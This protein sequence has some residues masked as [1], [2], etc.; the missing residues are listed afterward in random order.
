M[1]LGG[2]VMSCECSTSSTNNNSNANRSANCVADTVRFINRLQQAVVPS[3]IGCSR[4]NTPVLGETSKA[5]TRP[6][7][8]YLPNGSAFR[9]ATLTDSPNEP[10]P[11]FRVEDV[12]GNCAT[13]RALTTPCRNGK[14]LDNQ[15]EFYGCSSLQSDEFLP[16]R[17]C[18]IVNLNDFM[19]IQCLNDVF[20]NLEMCDCY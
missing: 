4:C 10:I 8:L 20:L 1:Y 16:T 6:F 12:N 9:V 14:G 18:V 7:I 11:V 2:E 15:A 5:N 13:L 19:A 17:T 3:E